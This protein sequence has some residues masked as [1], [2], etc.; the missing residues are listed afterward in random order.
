MTLPPGI[1][2]VLR[3]FSF[4][5]GSQMLTTLIGGASA[6]FLARLLGPELYGTLTYSFSWYLTFITLTSLGLDMVLGREVGRDRNAAPRLAGSTLALRA[7]A[8][9]IIAF[10]SAAIALAVEPDPAA[11]QL[12]LVLSAALL[13][14]AIW[15]WCGSVFVAFENTRQQLAIDIAFRPMELGLTILILS[16]FAPKSILA[17]GIVHAALWWL[18]AGLGIVVIFKRMTRI[19]FHGFADHAWRL[20]KEGAPGIVYTLAVAW[21]LQSPIVLFRQIAGVGDTLGHFALAI[22]M[23]GYLLTVPYLVGCVALPVLSRSAARDDG[24]TRTAAKAMLVMIP[25]IGVLFG[26][27]GIWLAPPLTVLVFGAEYRQAGQVL[28]ESVWLLTPL[29]LAIGLQQ[30]L[31]S[32]R[33][34]LGMASLFA[35]LGI[36]GMATLYAPLT[37]ALSYRGALLA[38]GIGI[39]IWAGGLVLALVTAGILARP[40]QDPMLRAAQGRAP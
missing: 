14:R 16:F 18:Q 13:G 12:L 20:V 35:I 39:T 9:T 33:L 30:I 10:L 38:T 6:V 2:S 31:F 17:V 8:A 21:F 22:Q 11:R 26:L 15:L 25:L 34:K 36:A 32:R 4:L 3:N 29:S 28:G 7:I 23:T 1:H 27:L 24:K 19:D 40:A 37:E 5:F